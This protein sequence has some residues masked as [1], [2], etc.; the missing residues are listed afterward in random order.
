M[1]ISC[2]SCGIDFSPTSGRGTVYSFAVV[3]RVY[4]PGFTDA[5]PYVVGVVELEEG[6]RLPT[7]IVGSPIGDVRCGSVKRVA[8]GVGEGAAAVAQIHAYLAKLHA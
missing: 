2:E 4:H 1:P 7:T 5:V 8:A 6:P 3:H